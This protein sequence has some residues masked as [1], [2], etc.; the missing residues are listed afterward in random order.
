MRR[1]MGTENNRLETFPVIDLDNRLQG[2][3]HTVVNSLHC[4]SSSFA[5]YAGFAIPKLNIRK[6]A[7]PLIDIQ[8]RRMI[9]TICILQQA[10]PFSDTFIEV[11]GYF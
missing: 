9:G 7:R 3:F 2:L 11:D 6:K 10:I 1:G 4:F 8:R 5:Y